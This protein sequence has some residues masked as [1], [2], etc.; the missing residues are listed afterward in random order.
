MSR[1]DLEKNDPVGLRMLMFSKVR[2][3]GVSFL[4]TFWV[5]SC[6]N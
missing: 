3:L 1:V 2:A 6:T 4:Y 5:A